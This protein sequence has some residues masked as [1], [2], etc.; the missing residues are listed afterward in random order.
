MILG[1]QQKLA[2]TNTELEVYINN[3]RIENVDKFKY[4]GIWLDPSLTWSAHFDKLTSTVSKRNGLLRRLRNTLPQKTLILLYK[5]LTV[6]HFDYCDVVWGNA[7][8]KYLNR[9]DTLQ[10][11]AGKIILGLP[12]RYPTDALLDRLSWEKLEDRRTCHL[13]TLVYKSLTGLLPSYLSNIFHAVS[14]SHTYTTRAASHGN[15]VPPSNKSNSALRK[16]SSR[17]VTSF[18]KLPTSVKE[19]LPPLFITS[20]VQLR[21][22]LTQLIASTTAIFFHATIVLSI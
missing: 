12:R 1:T 8:K 2:R 15:L 4:L 13:N 10:N 7:T 19:P 9:L 6:P 5:S 3:D 20:N 18:N 11:T 21:P 22:N 16:F 14:N 17:G